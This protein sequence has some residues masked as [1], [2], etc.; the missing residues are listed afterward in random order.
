MV[1][2]KMKS[3]LQR[4][5]DYVENSNIHPVLAIHH[6][7]TSVT[8]KDCRGYIESSC[9]TNESFYLMEL[10]EEDEGEGYEIDW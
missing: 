3:W 8:A 9:E 1:F 7:I 5:E 6:A 4:H 2:G 10:E